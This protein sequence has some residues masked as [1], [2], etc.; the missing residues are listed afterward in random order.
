MSSA[1]TGHPAFAEG[2]KWARQCVLAF[3]LVFRTLIAL[4]IAASAGFGLLLGWIAVTDFGWSQ[5][6]AVS[7]AHDLKELADVG[8]TWRADTIHG[9]CTWIADTASDGWA[10]IVNEFSD[11]ETYEDYDPSTDG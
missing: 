4:V 6:A 10:S 1:I 2:L 8:Y 3:C 7:G 9:G 11:H 5:R